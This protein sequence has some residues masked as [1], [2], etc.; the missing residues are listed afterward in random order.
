MQGYLKKV[1]P[2]APYN[3][4]KKTVTRNMLWQK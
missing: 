2:H 1:H 4:I 3:D